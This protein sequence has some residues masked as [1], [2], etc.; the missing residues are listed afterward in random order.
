MAYDESGDFY[1]E[2]GP[3]FLSATQSCGDFCVISPN[4]YE[5]YLI[6]QERNTRMFAPVTEET[7]K[8][9]ASEMNAINFKRHG[10]RPLY[11]GLSISAKSPLGREI[12]Q[13]RVR[14]SR[15]A[16]NVGIQVA[17]N[18][19]SF[20][21]A[22]WREARKPFLYGLRD[23][24]T[25]PYKKKKLSLKQKT[26][27]WILEQTV[28]AGAATLDLDSYGGGQGQYSNMDFDIRDTIVKF[29]PRLDPI[30]G[31]YGVR[32]KVRRYLKKNRPA[33]LNL[34]LNYCN[35]SHSWGEKTCTYQQ[36]VSAGFSFKNPSQKWSYYFYLSYQTDSL[37]EDAYIVDGQ[38][39]EHK[40][41]LSGLTVSYA[42][43]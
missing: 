21:S 19:K 42:F 22:L 25:R 27:I 35:S 34:N 4:Y 30:R 24:I 39:Y 9:E 11:R 29:N 12:I 18:E 28:D 37:D 14:W 10:S 31:R 33:F 15:F 38:P 41:W 26:E 6:I 5:H 1:R 17:E 7:I 43:Y 2:E 32:F 36:E 16:R 3:G 40:P 20:R 8:D 13:R 23:R